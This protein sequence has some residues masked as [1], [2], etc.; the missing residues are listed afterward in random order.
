MI[1]M[2]E[3][4]KIVGCRL[5]EL[6]HKFLCLKQDK[7]TEMMLPQRTQ[8][9]YH[10]GLTASFDLETINSVR[11]YPLSIKWYINHRHFCV[12][13]RVELNDGTV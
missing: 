8:Y 10:T 3:D 6:F 13:G 7:S 9:V 11:S 1:R 12:L 5:Y 2:K 4:L